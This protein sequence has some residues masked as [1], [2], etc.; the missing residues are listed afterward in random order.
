MPK[1]TT[2][3]FTDEI[4]ARLDQASSRTGLPV[5]SIVV[6]ACLEWMQRHTP[7]QGGDMPVPEFPLPGRVQISAPR[8]ATLRRAVEMAVGNRP[9]T[10]TYPFQRFTDPAKVMLTKSQEIAGQWGHSYIGTEH[11]LLAAFGSEADFHSAR[12]LR[13]MGVAESVVISAIEA[14][15]GKPEVSTR[16]RLIPT[17]RVKRVIEIAFDQC[18]ARGDSRVGTDHVLLALAAEGHGIAAHVLRDVGATTEKIE[19]EMAL[20]TEPEA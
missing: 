2:V 11:L 13:A 5:N 9:R 8:W 14:E 7:A 10:G 12:I 17:S 16:S 18:S 19:S 6:A 3:R 20:L 15:L 4:F 1:A